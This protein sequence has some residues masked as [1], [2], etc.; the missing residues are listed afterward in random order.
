MKYCLDN[1]E[2]LM[3]TS[4]GTSSCKICFIKSTFSGNYICAH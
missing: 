1:V 4:I 3:A 2:T